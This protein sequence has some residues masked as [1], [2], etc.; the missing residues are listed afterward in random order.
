MVLR[1]VGLVVIAVLFATTWIKL[2][3]DLPH[4][5]EH[6]PTGFIVAAIVILGVIYLDKLKKWI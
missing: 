6:G 5:G 3:H 2:G 1:I 4:L